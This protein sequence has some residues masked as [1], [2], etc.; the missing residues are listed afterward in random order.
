MQDKFTLRTAMSEPLASNS[1]TLPHQ[2]ARSTTIGDPTSPNATSS[3]HLQGKAR[4][5]DIQAKHRAGEKSAQAPE[6]SDAQN[7]G[8]GR[9]RLGFRHQISIGNFKVWRKNIAER[10]DEAE[11][12]VEPLPDIPPDMFDHLAPDNA[13]VDPTEPLVPDTVKRFGETLVN[14]KID[15]E[16]L[17]DFKEVL[18]GK[19]DYVELPAWLGTRMS[20]EQEPVKVIDVLTGAVIEVFWRTYNPHGPTTSHRMAIVDFL[21]VADPRNK[22]FVAALQDARDLA[23]ACLQFRRELVE[24][25]MGRDQ[26]D[27]AWALFV[28]R[29]AYVTDAIRDLSDILEIYA[30]GKKLEDNEKAAGFFIR[31]DS[32]GSMTNR[33]SLDNVTHYLE[34]RLNS[35][36]P[37]KNYHKQGT[38]EQER[39]L[40]AAKKAVIEIRRDELLEN[41]ELHMP[42]D[43]NVAAAVKKVLRVPVGAKTKPEYTLELARIRQEAGDQFKSDWVALQV[44]HKRPAFGTKPLSLQDARDLRAWLSNFLQQG[45]DYL[46]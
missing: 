27:E 7:Q 21:A 2:P 29:K 20:A 46:A 11:D 26:I 6:D 39:L 15:C 36:T 17:Q 22:V 13:K 41:L 34:G 9:R 33:A 19:K 25:G 38:Q 42:T 30:P 35:K 24:K 4:G 14:Q 37:S 43:V 10:G 18:D 8:A 40:E 1:P 44:T 12:D 5:R 31:F 3:L 45:V 16:M 32:K 28:N 23:D